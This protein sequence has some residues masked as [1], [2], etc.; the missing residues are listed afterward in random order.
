MKHSMFR[1]V[2]WGQAYMVMDGHNM[3]VAYM[4]KV[5]NFRSIISTQAE[6]KTIN[7][8][9]QNVVTFDGTDNCCRLVKTA[10]QI[11][12]QSFKSVLSTCGSAQ[13]AIVKPRILPKEKIPHVCAGSAAQW[14]EHIRT[15]INFASNHL[16]FEHQKESTGH[17]WM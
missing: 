9:Q 6:T 8:L 10:I 11:D 7:L 1:H 16:F 13:R 4:R 5:R 2:V 14:H 12:V 3:N 17:A 15:F